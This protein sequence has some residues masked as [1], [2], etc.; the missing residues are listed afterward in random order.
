MIEAGR[1]A[2]APPLGAG[3]LRQFLGP[4]RRRTGSRSRA[5]AS[6]RAICSRAD[7]LIQPLDEPLLPR[8]SA[9]ASL[10]TCALSQR[11]PIIG[12]IFHVHSPAATR[13]LARR[14]GRGPPRPAGLGTAEGASPA[15]RR[16]RRASRFRSSPTTRIPQR[17][18]ATCRGAACGADAA[19]VI[20]APGYLLAGHG[21]Y[22]WGAYAKR[23]GPP[24]RSA[25]NAVR[26]RA[27][28]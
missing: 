15:S 10:H 27:F 4:H 20:L 24:S 8:S 9:E 2:A 16:T 13:A 19:D 1:A 5:R 7:I 3:H 6:T 22:A 17:L 26:I 21:L 11:G 23:G 28:L 14:R 12:A 18:A 25:R